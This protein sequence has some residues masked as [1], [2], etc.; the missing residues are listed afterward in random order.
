M[1]KINITPEVRA[2]LESSVIDATSLKLPSTPLDRKLYVAVNKVIEA[3]GG[4]WNKSLKAHVFSNDP[5][6]ELGL[7]LES[8][9][10]VDKVKERKKERQAFYTPENIAT[11]VAFLADVWERDVL[12]P[13][14]GHGALAAACIESGA[15]RFFVLIMQM[16]L[17]KL[18]KKKVLKLSSQISLN[19][20]RHQMGLPMSVLL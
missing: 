13:S 15:K 16:N 14:A 4:K 3:A 18:L 10:I 8:N 2:V 7:A 9:V 20:V 19:F 17:S 11:T 1:S 5:R 6:V 12:E